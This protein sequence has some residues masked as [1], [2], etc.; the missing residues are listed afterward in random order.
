MLQLYIDNQHQV[1]HVEERGLLCL[2]NR[3]RQVVSHSAIDYHG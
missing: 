3:E 1:S 2:P